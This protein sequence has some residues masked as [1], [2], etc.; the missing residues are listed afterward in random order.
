MKKEVIIAILIGFG[1][2]LLITLG[3]HATR[4]KETTV[5]NP[6][7]Q[8]V[9]TPAVD[10]EHHITVLTPLENS[11][12]SAENLLIKGQTTPD[13]MVVLETEKAHQIKVSDESGF[14]ETEYPLAP[15]PNQINITSYS[16]N[17]SSATYMLETT[18]APE[19]DSSA[20]NEEDTSDE[21]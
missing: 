10:T 2:G 8:V 3:I 7:S 16:P 20:Q 13:S 19:T 1:I 11:V 21:S 17:G 15:G 12:Q 6:A 5:F 14:F 18:Y 4:K 9:P